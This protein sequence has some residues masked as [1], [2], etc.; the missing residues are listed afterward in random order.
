MKRSDLSSPYF[1]NYYFWVILAFAMVKPSW[2]YASVVAG[3][4]GLDC[5]KCHD[6]VVEVLQQ[7]GGAHASLCLECHQGHPPADMDIIPLCSSCHVGESHFELVNCLKCHEDP[8]AP[9]SIKLTHDIT[10]PC[11]TCHVGQFEQLQ[12]NPSIHTQLACTA[13]HNF[14]GQLQP[15]GNCHKPHSDTMEPDSCVKCHSA[16]KPLAVS[17]GPGIVSADCGSCHVKA[18]DVLGQTYTKHRQVGCVMCH[19]DRHGNIPACVQC[20]VRPHPDV[21]IGR[22]V[23]CGQCHG[24]A[25]DMEATSTATSIYLKTRRERHFLTEGEP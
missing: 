22:F 9:L 24:L 4:D 5:A 25:H 1:S 8:H 7:K 15:C 20:H 2:V 21:I 23:S 12:A 16:H 13:C 10:V 19:A 6:R 17:Y 11:L 3:V 14:H 18:Y